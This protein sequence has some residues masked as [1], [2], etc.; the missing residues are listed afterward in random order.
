MGPRAAGFLVGAVAA[1]FFSAMLLQYDILRK[2]DITDRE[3]SLLEKEASLIR[4]RFRR[5]QRALIDAREE[6]IETQVH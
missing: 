1:T 6:E 4:E 5:A 3:I 2:K